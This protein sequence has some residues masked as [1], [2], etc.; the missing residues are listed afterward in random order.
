MSSLTVHEIQGSS[1]S[2][3]T[4]TVKS[5]Q[6]LNAPTLKTDTLSGNTTA[7]SISVTGEGNSTTTNL[8]QG[9]AKCWITF[10]M[11]TSNDI[12][13]SFN[14]SSAGDHATGVAQFTINN[15]MGN[16]EYAAVSGLC[17]GTYNG[18]TSMPASNGGDTEWHVATTYWY[19]ST[20]GNGATVS[21]FDCERVVSGV[22]GD[23]A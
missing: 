18:S 20:R 3:N 12:K 10:D 19:H 23:L 16:S 2:S 1:S 4:I 7:G 6:T 17:S 15:N 14:I 22:L 5:G 8:Q 21:L 9:L 13:D 11:N